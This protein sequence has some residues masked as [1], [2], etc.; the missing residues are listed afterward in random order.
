M[1][2][3]LHT[4]PVN[5]LTTGRRDISASTQGLSTEQ[6]ASTVIALSY[7]SPVLASSKPP[8]EAV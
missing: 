8:Q 2:I 5:R 4:E 7:P 3:L 1:P 6:H